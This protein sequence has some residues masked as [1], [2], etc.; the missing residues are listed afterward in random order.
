MHGHP[1]CTTSWP[2]KYSRAQH[3]SQARGSSTVRSEGLTRRASRAARRE[4]RGQY[5]WGEVDVQYKQ[6]RFLSH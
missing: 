6:Y 4:P 1:P 2:C 5:S 3:T